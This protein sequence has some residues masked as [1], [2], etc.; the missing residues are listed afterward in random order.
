MVMDRP[1][2]QQG[3]FDG[4]LLKRLTEHFVLASVYAQILSNTV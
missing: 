2:F 1:R 3:N 4:R